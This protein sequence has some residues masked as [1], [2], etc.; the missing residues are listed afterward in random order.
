M[1]Q[2]FSTTSNFLVLFFNN[3][4]IKFEQINKWKS[5]HKISTL[6]V[7]NVV[8]K[9]SPHSCPI[10]TLEFMNLRVFEIVYISFLTSGWIGFFKWRQVFT[11]TS[12]TDWWV[13][14]AASR[15][16]CFILS[17]KLSSKLLFPFFPFLFVFTGTCLR[18]STNDAWKKQTGREQKS[19][20]D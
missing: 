3:P 14:S 15:Y 13:L 16:T 8:L 7:L 6:V 4:E 19:I 10:F 17:F 1:S 9:V 18:M 20:S 11:D 2:G 12:E 5:E